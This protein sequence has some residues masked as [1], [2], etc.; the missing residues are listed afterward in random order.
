MDAIAALAHEVIGPVLAGQGF[1][2]RGSSFFLRGSGPNTGV[3]SV[4]KSRH[5]GATKFTLNGGVYSA[6]LAGCGNP[7][8]SVWDC[9]YQ[10]RIGSLLTPPRDLWWLLPE[11]GSGSP[12]SGVAD[13]V[14]AAILDWLV[15]DVRRHLAD[16]DL[17][18]YWMTRWQD[19]RASYLEIRHLAGL[20]SEIGP[21]AALGPLRAIVDE[22]PT[23]VRG[24][25]DE[26][27]RALE[28]YG[29]RVTSVSGHPR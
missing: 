27:A 17:R 10:T 1:R 15:P 13:D 2:R 14:V 23:A 6:Q 22:G 11:D 9:H 21:S 28:S 29:F 3:V 18:D 5:S 16:R 19:G 25:D 8:P 26:L 4:Q 7:S 12:S 24:P 20:V